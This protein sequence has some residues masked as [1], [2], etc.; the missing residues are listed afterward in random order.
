[1]QNK[2]VCLIERPKSHVKAKL[3]LLIK[4]IDRD[5]PV[6]KVWLWTELGSPGMGPFYYAKNLRKS[7]NSRL[8]FGP[9][10]FIL[11]LLVGGKNSLF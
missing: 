10:G 9:K 8:N 11:N 7:G 3:A 2:N 6:G 1:L 4:R 5:D